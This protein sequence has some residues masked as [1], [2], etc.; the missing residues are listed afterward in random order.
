MLVVV[1]VGDQH[2]NVAMIERLG[3][4]SQVVSPFVPEE[5]WQDSS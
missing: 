1:V 2:P 4:K 3:V 5:S